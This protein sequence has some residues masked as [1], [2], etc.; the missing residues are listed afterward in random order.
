MV[1]FPISLLVIF[2]ELLR[3]ATVYSDSRQKSTSFRRIRTT[4]MPTCAHRDVAGLRFVSLAVIAFSVTA[5]VMKESRHSVPI[6][7]N[8]TLVSEHTTS[9]LNAPSISS[10][11]HHNNS[12]KKKR[13]IRA[14]HASCTLHFC[15]YVLFIYYSSRCL[16]Q[17]A[18][19]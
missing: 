1:K 10:M 14:L 9:T 18:F 16:T 4:Y 15:Q 3:S 6:S 5:R 7:Q 13:P 11:E 2:R 8:I 17:E 19:V 12:M